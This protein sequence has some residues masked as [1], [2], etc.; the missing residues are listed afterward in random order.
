MKQ[1][2]R[3]GNNAIT[4][5]SFPFLALLILVIALG[6]GPRI[7][8][9]G[10]GRL[11]IGQ[12]YC[13]PPTPCVLTY[14]N[15]NSRNGVNP[16]ESTLKASTLSSTHHPT[17]QWLA[18]T[19][20]LIYA[21]PLYVNQLSISGGNKNV[22]YAATEN[23]SV[24]AFD[25]DS[26][27]N[28]GT[29]LAQ[30]NLNNASDLGSGYTEI[31]VPS[32][33]LP[34]GCKN[35]QPE[36]GITGT[37]VIDVSVT[38]PILYVV[39]KHEDVDISGK[40][41]FRQKLHALY[42]DTLQ[43]LPG[44]PL[45]LDAAF[46]KSNAPGFNPLHN[47]Q[48]AGLA[49][50]SDGTTAGIWV[51]WASHCDDVPYHGFAIRLSYDYQG[52]SFLPNYTVFNSEKSCKKQTCQGGI[53]MGGA[54][55]AV[56][57]QG[58]VYLSTGNG[59][60]TDQGVAEFS[61]SIVKLNDGGWRDSY[62]PPDFDGM[63]KG[64][65]VV[66]CTNPNPPHCPSPCK[67]DNTGHY[68][69]VTLQADDWDL[70]SSGVVLISPTFPLNNPEMLTAGK[71]GMIYLTFANGLG[72][73]DAAWSH[74]DEYACT[75]SAVPKPGAIAQCF[76]GF[77]LREGEQQ[78]DSGSRGSAA[79]LAAGVHNYLYIAGIEDSLK[80]FELV[81]QKGLG[82]F[83]LTAATPVAPHFFA[84]PGA[85]PAVTWN[86]GTGGNAADALVWTLDEGG[87][88]THAKAASAAVLYAYKAI[89]ARLAAGG[90][91]STLWTTSAYNHTVPGS[92]GAVKF[93]VPTIVDSKIFI[94]GGAQHYHPG[95]A[96]CPTPS[97][98]VQPTNCGGLAMFK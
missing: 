14:H 88:G 9:S 68:C 36:A 45:L 19:D 48:R 10:K 57:T 42:I 37:P 79:F 24:Y 16:F 43:E 73:T 28:T 82:T 25:A 64:A 72:G 50:V 12:T 15:N 55:P 51:A 31:A 39:S 77:R 7:L 29:V 61:N 17:P 8:A 86:S 98:T 34:G 38:P 85:S 40:K 35:I 49:L 69:Q 47:N 59:D 33:D 97:T 21:Q 1:S 5:S 46:A 32:T 18:A 52:Q 93:V 58:N 11:T 71:Q 30:T 13:A 44:S 91:G 54:A 23:N 90:L 78:P 56:D 20:G 89:P 87:Y 62:T 66:A 53:W 4:L 26:T 60:D 3:P 63:N 22:V 83:N 80:A 76:L 27:V 67:M 2:P 75:T 70:G 41:T 95:S 84:Y 6:G 92:P 74:P 96:N 65:A 94:A 81:N